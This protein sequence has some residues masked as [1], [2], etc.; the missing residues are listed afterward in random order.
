MQ[1][2]WQRGSKSP[3]VSMPPP[4]GLGSGSGILHLSPD[5]DPSPLPISSSPTAKR[6]AAWAAS[7]ANS[8]IFR[9]I[10]WRANRGERRRSFAIVCSPGARPTDSNSHTHRF[11]SAQAARRCVRARM[12]VHPLKIISTAWTRAAE[13]WCQ[14]SGSQS[15]ATRSYT[16]L[17][18]GNFIGIIGGQE[19]HFRAV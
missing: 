6:S 11:C 3:A 15:L 1:A 14:L 5:P 4:R 18:A 2:R 7:N 13:S 8:R 12:R 17:L 19:H 9:G 10:S 16:I